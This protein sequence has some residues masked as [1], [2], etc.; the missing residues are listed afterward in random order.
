VQSTLAG[1]GET[2][3][4]DETIDVIALYYAQ[5]WTDGLPVVPPTRARVQAMVERSG[6]A[7]SE[8][9]AEL[10]P[11]GGKATVERIATNAVMAGCLPEYMP[12]ILTALEAALAAPCSH[13]LLLA[14]WKAGLYLREKKLG[15]Y[16]MQGVSCAF[17][18]SRHGP[19]F[20]GLSMA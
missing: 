3:R 4:I 14:Q 15:R 19:L 1:V 20:R 6:R 12:V 2:M 10:P 9:I 5:S 8:V 7:A 16:Y 11:Q 18:F 17:T 13:N